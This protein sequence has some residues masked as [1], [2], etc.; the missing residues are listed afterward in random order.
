[1]TENLVE[2]LERYRKTNGGQSDTVDLFV[3]FLQENRAKSFCRSLAEGHVTAS[4]WLLNRAQTHV[5]LTHHRKLNRWLQLGGH[6]D[7]ESDP[8]KVAL[9]EASEESGIK[10]IRILTDDIFDID[11]HVIPARKNEPEHF[12][13]DFRFAMQTT[14]SD[15]Y[16]V[17]DESHDLRW[18]AISRMAQYTADESVLRMGEKWLSRASNS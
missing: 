9:A 10:S 4:C 6:A 12:H 13:F 18:V 2:R 15:D 8:V 17:S 16:V 3:A 14:G 11:R 7:G 1:V 5:L